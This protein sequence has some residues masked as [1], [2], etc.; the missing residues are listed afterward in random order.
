[1]IKGVGYL[2]TFLQ[3]ILS[4]GIFDELSKATFGPSLLDQSI[5]IIIISYIYFSSHTAT[6]HYRHLIHL[7]HLIDQ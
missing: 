1:M 6:I 2:G 4:L 5:S 3:K 7:V